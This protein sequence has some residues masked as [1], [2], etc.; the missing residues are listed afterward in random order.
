DLHSEKAE[1]LENRVDYTF[2]WEKKGVYVPWEEGGAKLLVG[3]TI[4]GKEVR[5]FYGEDLDIPEKFIRYV[6]RQ[7][8]LG[9][10]ITSFSFIVLLVWLGWAAMIIATRR[11]SLII[12]LSW[13][14]YLAIGAGIFILSI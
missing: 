2:A 1:K 11:Y 4:S 5:T 6:N 13:R 7:L 14:W 9:S 3:A 10:L 12:R 8:T